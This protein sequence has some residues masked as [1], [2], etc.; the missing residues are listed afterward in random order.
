MNQPRER[1]LVEINGEWHDANDAV[2]TVG[3]PAPVG[4]LISVEDGSKVCA[5]QGDCLRPFLGHSL[6]GE[7]RDGKPTFAIGAKDTPA[8]AKPEY[9]QRTRY[10]REP[11][12]DPTTIISDRDGILWIAV[13]VE[14]RN[15]VYRVGCKGVLEKLPI[16]GFPVLADEAG[17]VWLRHI[18]A[19]DEVA[20]TF[21]VWRDGKVANTLK[22]PEADPNTFFFSDRPGSV[23]AWTIRGLQ[24][25]VADGP[26]FKQFRLGKLYPIEGLLGQGNWRGYSKY[27]YLVTTS[28]S[29]TPRRERNYLYLFK[30]PADENAPP[31]RNNV[32][33]G[34]KKTYWAERRFGV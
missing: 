7:V 11:K 1:L 22:I 33:P 20:D 32:P 18:A 9:D 5:V 30:L 10:I 3:S 21:D 25:L 31:A 26:D 6:L 19:E 29:W 16:A 4:S 15:V 17:N 23:Y 12:V 14:G 2:A 27:G 13:N 34:R 8:P 24:H 28:F